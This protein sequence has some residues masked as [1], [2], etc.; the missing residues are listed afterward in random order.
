MSHIKRSGAR[1]ALLVIGRL[2]CDG[3]LPTDVRQARSLLF[4]CRATYGSADERMVPRQLDLS[5]IVGKLMLKSASSASSPSGPMCGGRFA[6]PACPCHGRSLQ[7]LD[8]LRDGRDHGEVC[9]RNSP[10]ARGR[11]R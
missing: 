6:W 4:T 9:R 8:C 11:T 10:P 7:A 1:R 5:S 3:C 2:M